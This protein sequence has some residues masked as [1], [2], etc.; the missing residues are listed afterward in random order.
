MRYLPKSPADREAMLREIGA[1]SIDEL[2]AIIPE[3]FRLTRDLAIPRQMGESE[4]V[5]HFQAAAAR[6]ANGYA[7]FLGAGAYRHYRPVLIDTIVQRGEFLTSYTP[8]QAEITQGT[9]QAIFEFQTMICE[10]T[11]MDIANASMYDG[12]TGAAEAV[13]MAIRVTGRDKVLVSR[14]VHPEYREVMHTYAQHQG[15]DAAEVEYIREGAQAGRVDL[16]ALEAAVTEETACVLVQSP[17]FFGVIEDIPAI[18]EI[19]HKKGALLIVSIAEAL[20][21]GAVRPPVEADIVSLEAQSFGVALSYGGPYCGV[22]AAKEK[23]LRQMP[24]RL[25]GETKDSQGRRGFVL[26]LSTREQH[27][28]REKATSNICT[29]QALVALMATVYM[30]I[31]GKQGIK[32]LALQNLA[33]ADYAAKTLGQSGKLLFAGSPRFHEFVLETSETPAQVNE[34]LLEEKII[35]GLPLGKWYPELGH[36]ALWCATEVTTRE[37][38]DRA[39]QVLAHAPALA[40]R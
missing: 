14:S 37:Q 17:N 34:R 31:Y 19:A 6:N 21:L 35:G 26:T 24:G 7:S 39:A 22:L 20:S 1:A 2:F 16:A 15:H 28:R 29:N 4:I 13:M 30:T 36:A 3:E 38:I 33:K 11:G 10:L 23:Y 32:D 18:A 40:A 8:Y 25:V 9:L 12:S 27:I 5:D